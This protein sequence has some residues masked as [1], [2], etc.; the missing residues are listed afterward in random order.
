MDNL[1]HSLAGLAVGELIHRSLPQ[2]P[3]ADRQSTRRRML[4]AACAAA[5]NF[6]DLDLLLRGRLPEPIGYLLDHRGHTHTFLFAVPQALLLMALVWLLWPGA[7]RLLHASG[8]ARRGLVLAAAL[9]LCMHIGFDFLNSYGV[10]PFYPLDA[11]WFYGDT[12]FIVEPVLWVAFGAPLIMMVRRPWL[13]AL[14]ALL[15]AAI[16]AF[17]TARGLLHWGSAA[18]LLALGAALMALQRR[19]GA[20]GRRALLA[21]MGAA[22]VLVIL[23]AQ[24]AAQGRAAVTAAL[25]HSVPQARVLDVAMTPFPA[26]P[27]CWS[28]VSVERDDAR[29]VY[30]LRRGL[31]SPAPGMMSIDACP[32][33]FGMPA[34]RG[35]PGLG[36]AWT[37]EAPLAALRALARHCRGKAWLRFARMP[38]LWPQGATDA[39][40]SPSEGSNFS[41]MALDGIGEL[42]CPANMPAWDMPRADLLAPPW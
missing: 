31:F 40:F 27:L 11:G 23:Q 29:A 41:T 37:H 26:N 1:T 10:H 35:A 17:S 14:F 9:G 34:V 2:E 3:D 30:R 24:L 13:R 8:A 15:L 6:P 33:G 38:A 22:A 42:D 21:G 7:R 4:L 19:S 32:S 16:F 28:F 36:F 25:R 18:A 20:C 5:N 12:L 39:R